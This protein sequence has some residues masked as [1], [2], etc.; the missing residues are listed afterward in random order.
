MSSSHTS[1]PDQTVS[2]RTLP[3][4]F[5]L[6]VLTSL[7]LSGLNTKIAGLSWLLWLSWSVYVTRSSRR[8]MGLT[9]DREP[10]GQCAQVWVWGLLLYATADLAMAWAWHDGCCAYTSEVNSYVRLLLAA[11]ATLLLVRH[12]VTWPDMRHHINLAVALALIMGFALAAAS[13][14]NLPSHPIP[15]A[16]AMV[17]LVCVLMPHVG[18]SSHSKMRRWLYG[19]SSVLGMAAVV[20]SQSRGAFVVLAFPLVLIVIHGRRAWSRALTRVGA[21]CIAAAAILVSLTAVPSDPLRLRLAAGEVSHA[22]KTQDFNS[23]LGARVYLNQLAWD[24]F[25]RFPWTGVGATQRLELIQSAGL[26]LPPAQSDGLSH[27]RT[28]GHVHNQYLHHA[29]DNGIVGLLG[30]LTLLVCMGLLCIRLHAISRLASLQMTLITLSHAAG[31]LS[32]VNLAH[33]YYALMWGLCVGLVFLQALDTPVEKAP[34]QMQP[35]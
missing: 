12:V 34:P 7:A 16:G 22:L 18:D 29:L 30:L 19:V 10:M 17:F 26:D 15:W 21:A 24:H 13:E 23:S 6:A 5:A 11:V 9:D 8:S 4:G 20:L 28:L 1:L 25:A 35:R 2:K 14:R 32:N 33:N 31:S 3:C 27:V